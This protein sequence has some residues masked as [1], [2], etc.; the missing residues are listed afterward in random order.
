[1][2]ITEKMV[3]QAAKA[4]T[5]QFD[6]MDQTMQQYALVQMKSALEAALLA[7]EVPTISVGTYT[8]TEL[9]AGRTVATDVVIMKPADDIIWLQKG[10]STRATGGSNHGE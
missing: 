10:P 3:L 6:N 2:E 7:H 5:P 9:Y 1:M 4:H 8:I